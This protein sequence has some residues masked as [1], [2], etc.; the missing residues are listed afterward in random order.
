M[1]YENFPSSWEAKES[2]KVLFSENEI[3]TAGNN[4]ALCKVSLVH[5]ITERTILK[6]VR[7]SCIATTRIYWKP[8]GTQ[9]FLYIAGLIKFR[10]C[11]I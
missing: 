7:K 6:L 9:A 5:L 2:F 11:G 1:A 8:I 4:H 3:P 10:C